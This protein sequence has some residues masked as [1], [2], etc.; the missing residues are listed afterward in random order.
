MIAVDTNVL[1]RLFIL[2]DQGQCAT[3]R[4]LVAD[5]GPRGILI[6]ALVLA[7]L[8]RVYRRKLGRDLGMAVELVDRILEAPEFVVESQ[9]V[10]EDALATYRAGGTDFSDC[11]IAATARLAGATSLYTFDAAAARR[12]PGAVLLST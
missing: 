10:V 6:P 5:Q 7:E 8:V 9:S 4:R 2:D 11:L 3:A 12:I 1:L